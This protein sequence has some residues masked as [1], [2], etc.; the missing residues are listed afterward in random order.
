MYVGRLLLIYTRMDRQGVSTTIVYKRTCVFKYIM[1]S[2]Q[3]I[4]ICNQ[5]LYS[6]S[7][8]PNHIEMVLYRTIWTHSTFNQNK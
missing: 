7:D 4:N 1:W 3:H 6:E 8:Y 5:V 2:F